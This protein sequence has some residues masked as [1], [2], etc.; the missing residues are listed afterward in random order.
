V[1]VTREASRE[2]TAEEALFMRI[3][4]WGV[5]DWEVA[6]IETPRNRKSS[7]IVFIGLGFRWRFMM[8]D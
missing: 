1:Y 2:I 7:F 3:I 5:Q 4:C 8:L 6:D